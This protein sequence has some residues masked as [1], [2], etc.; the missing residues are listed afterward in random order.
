L[1]VR[2][3][4]TPEVLDGE[5]KGEIPGQQGDDHIIKLEP[6]LARR[7]GRRGLKSHES[8]ARG[9]GQGV[10]GVGDTSGGGL[11]GKDGAGPVD[12]F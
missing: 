12:Y 4:G 7:G 11:R 2:N 5:R 6:R 9:G 1:E 8:L 3:F 10:E